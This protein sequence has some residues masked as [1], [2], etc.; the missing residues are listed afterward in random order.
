MS[1]IWQCNIYDRSIV[2]HETE[3]GMLL[4]EERLA[5]RIMADELS[6]DFIR[7]IAESTL[8]FRSVHNLIGNIVGR[9]EWTTENCQLKAVC[10]KIMDA[11]EKAMDLTKAPPTAG[12]IYGITRTTPTED[13]DVLIEPVY[14]VE[15]K[16]CDLEGYG[17]KR[18]PHTYECLLRPWMYK[19]L[20]AADTPEERKLWERRIRMDGV[21]GIME[22]RVERAEA[23]L[24]RD[25]VK[26]E[27]SSEAL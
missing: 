13:E 21:V 24:P 3:W 23:G 18:Y 9:H 14:M 15:P 19:V 17:V 26:Q 16:D 6:F 27:V 5:R 7:E 8:P 4:R 1:L 2:V 25:L 11:C 22:K 10:K 20:R 12:N